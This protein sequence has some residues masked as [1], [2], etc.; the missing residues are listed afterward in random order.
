MRK[1]GAGNA[2]PTRRTASYNEYLWYTRHLELSCTEIPKAVKVPLTTQRHK[3]SGQSIAVSVT[4]PGTGTYGQQRCVGQ[5]NKRNRR[6]QDR[7]KSI[8]S[9]GVVRNTV[10]KPPAPGFEALAIQVWFGEFIRFQQQSNP[11]LHNFLWD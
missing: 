4:V 10:S 8:E 6:T 11:R 7:I 1:G 3:V 2:R 9:F 5:V